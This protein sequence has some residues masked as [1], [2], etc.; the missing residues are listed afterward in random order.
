M[1]KLD[2]VTPGSPDSGQPLDADGSNI[3]VCY[4]RAIQQSGRQMRLDISWKLD[5]DEPYY[6]LWKTKF[7]NPQAHSTISS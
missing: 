3:V 4:H 1:I 5:L 6:T 7:V 2:Y